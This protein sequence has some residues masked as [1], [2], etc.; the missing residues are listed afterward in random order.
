[1]RFISKKVARMGSTFEGSTDVYG[2]LVAMFICVY[3]HHTDPTMGRNMNA[4]QKRIHQQKLS[5]TFPQA[6]LVIS[7]ASVSGLRL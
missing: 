7:G 4:K 6:A 2:S 5:D 1:M 3:L